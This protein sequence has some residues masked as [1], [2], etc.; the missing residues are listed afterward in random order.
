M[1][2]E[3]QPAG[4]TFARSARVNGTCTTYER[5]YIYIYIYIYNFIY[6]KHIYIYIYMTRIF[7][8]CTISVGLAPLANKCG[9]R[10][11][12]QLC[13]YREEFAQQYGVG[14]AKYTPD[15]AS[16]HAHKTSEH[17]S[18]RPIINYTTS[19]IQRINGASLKEHWAAQ[20]GVQT[21][22]IFIFYIFLYENSAKN[23]R[24]IQIAKA[25]KKV[26]PTNIITKKQQKQTN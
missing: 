14:L 17:T 7:L 15:N 13:M 6:K 20:S 11:A 8:S 4:P 25:N 2:V 3:P 16:E 5:I 23:A 19:A 22:Y 18:I 1:T 21:F 12:R 10:A 26:Y 9:A 24:D